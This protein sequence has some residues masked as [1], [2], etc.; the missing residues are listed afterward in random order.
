MEKLREYLRNERGR[1]TSLAAHLGLRPGTI[2]QWKQ[3][4]AEHLAEIERHTGLLRQDLRPEIFV[5][6][7]APEANE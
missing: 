5:G 7:R 6:M 2:I 4:P 1:L 3:I